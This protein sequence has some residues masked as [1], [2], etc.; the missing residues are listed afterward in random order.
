M[1]CLGYRPPLR[2]WARAVCRH[3][4][5]CVLCVTALCGPAKWALAGALD[6]F[7]AACSDPHLAGVRL[8]WQEQGDAGFSG[9]QRHTLEG[10]LSELVSNALEHAGA[11]LLTV[12]WTASAEAIVLSVADGGCG[13]PVT[14]ANAGQGLNSVRSRAA[15]CGGTAA[16]ERGEHGGTR[17]RERRHHERTRRPCGGTTARPHPGG[18]RPPRQRELA[19]PRR[20]PGLPRHRADDGRQLGQ[21]A[22]VC[23]ASHAGT[24]TGGFWIT[25]ATAASYA[26]T[27]YR[28]LDVTNRAEATRRGLIQP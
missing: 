7:T 21:R 6:T 23:A 11:G 22:R 24:G 27:L 2:P 8:R 25:A 15:Q 19:Q 26:K 16:W 3:V 5:A 10:V 14:P 18:G 4:L 9:S 12:D 28:K 20:A 17:C 1:R 13:L